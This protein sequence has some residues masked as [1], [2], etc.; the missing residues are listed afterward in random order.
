[1]S[2]DTTRAQR[3]VREG[4]DILSR[5]TG[6]GWQ[7]FGRLWSFTPEEHKQLIALQAL[8]DGYL[9]LPSPP[10]ALCLAVFGAPGSGKSFAVKE[11]CQEL[12]K[13]RTDGL[14]LP[15]T[16]IN[17]TQ[18]QSPAELAERL[19]EVVTST[20]ANAVPLIF[21]DEFDAPLAGSPMGWLHWFLVPMQDGNFQYTGKKLLLQRAVF[22]FAGGTAERLEDFGSADPVG[23]RAAKGPDFVSRLRGYLNVQG[24]NA[25]KH[26]K[27]RRAVLLRGA[28]EKVEEART[29]QKRAPARGIT[30]QLLDAMLHAGRYL[31]GARS[32]H[33]IIEMAAAESVR[34]GY[35]TD[36]ALND[37]PPDHVLAV[38]ADR[39]PLSPQC[40]G[41]LIGMSGGGQNAPYS[42]VW[43]QLATMLWMAGAV[44]AFGGDPRQGDLVELL[45][46]AKQNLPIQLSKTPKQPLRLVL[47]PASKDAE[48]E[49]VGMVQNDSTMQM[50]S[51]PVW[52]GA[53]DNADLRRVQELFAMRW[54]MTCRCR[55]R[56]FIG[57]RVAGYAGRMPGIFEEAMLALALRQPIYLLGGFGDAT[58][59]LGASLGLAGPTSALPE[60]K[61]PAATGF[62]ADRSQTAS[63][64]SPAGAPPMP[65]TF[66]EVFSWLPGFAIG[67]PSWPDNGLS[68]EA[69]QELFQTTDADKIVQ[70]VQE[71]LVRRM[72]RQE[73][74][75]SR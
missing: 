50:T 75:T 13:T 1:M 6:Q 32:I 10:R 73:Q 49:L 47:F 66:E 24:P 16:E 40:I 42:C 27:L 14:Q 7:R 67:G 57:G 25:L 64:F 52:T 34:R 71:G 31:H 54:R 26:T 20:E 21:F 43:Q 53:E 74:G 29:G 46:K 65:L 33:A 18:L 45:D 28:L 12:Q 60:L 41:G 9:R 8:L 59:A 30:D 3:I 35:V 4:A 58:A 23:F 68:L 15:I 48:K 69:N 2:D 70:M 72:T 51:G 19:A 17:L 11:V 62:H 5:E 44:I 56:I 55:A 63:Y 36:L 37:L 22:V 38:H 61:P 39:G